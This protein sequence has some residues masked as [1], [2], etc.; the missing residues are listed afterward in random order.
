MITIL[1]AVVISAVSLF[2]YVLIKAIYQFT[3]KK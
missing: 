3:S 1:E 2:A